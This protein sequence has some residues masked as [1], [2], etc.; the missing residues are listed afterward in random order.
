MYP[1]LWFWAP[2]FHFPFSGSLA[3]NIEPN[4]SWFSDMIKPSAGNAAI[5]QKAFGV[6]S[7]GKQLGQITDVLLEVVKTVPVTSP[8]ASQSLESLRKIKIQIDAIKD[9]EYSSSADRLITELRAMQARGGVQ[10]EGVAEQMRLLLSAASP[11]PAPKR[12]RL[13]RTA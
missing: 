7:Y 9:A 2:Q 1:W 11:E 5:E 10:Y 8:E 12:A 4:T 6:A 3:Q 13:S